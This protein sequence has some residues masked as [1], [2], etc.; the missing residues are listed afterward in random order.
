MQLLMFQIPEANDINDI[1]DLLKNNDSGSVC[2]NSHTENSVAHF[3]VRYA[4]S[5][6]LPKL[7]SPFYKG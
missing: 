5:N 7:I 6:S 2:Y 4:I 3:L 1:N